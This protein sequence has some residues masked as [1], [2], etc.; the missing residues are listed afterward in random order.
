MAF[1]S[2]RRLTC[3]A[4]FSPVIE[5]VVLIEVSSKDDRGGQQVFVFKRLS[6]DR[7]AYQDD[8]LIELFIQGLGYQAV[9]LAG[10]HQVQVRAGVVHADD[11]QVLLVV[12]RSCSCPGGGSVA[13]GGECR[14]DIGVA[15]DDGASFGNCA[16]R[17]EALFLSVQDLDIR[18]LG[19]HLFR[20]GGRHQ[21]FGLIEAAYRDSHS[22]F[23][24][25][26][27]A[28]GVSGGLGILDHIGAYHSRQPGLFLRKAGEVGGDDRNALG[29]EFRNGGEEAGADSVVHDAVDRLGQGLLG[30]RD[31]VLGCGA[32]GQQ[33]FTIVLELC[34]G[35]AE[36]QLHQAVHRV[37]LEELHQ[38]NAMAFGSGRRWLSGLLSWC[39]GG[40]SRGCGARRQDHR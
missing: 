6:V 24:G 25:Q 29:F 8:C 22:A 26:L 2:G 32:V 35:I 20:E 17:I 33:Q 37:P 11:H 21:V 13:G 30:Q 12:V 23:A 19:G 10:F 9:N 4:G 39:T 15:L 40:S 14:G 28:D 27:F 31:H 38:S 1:G 18:I 16:G 34:T 7:L 5:G 3:N 36:A